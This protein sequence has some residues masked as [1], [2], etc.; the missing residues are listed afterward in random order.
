M[1]RHQ[2][3]RTRLRFDSV[4]GQPRQVCSERGEVPLE[5]VD[6]AGSAPA[7]VAEAVRMRYEEQNFD[8]EQE[9]PVRTAVIRSGD[10]LTHMVAIYLHLAID[11]TGF[12]VLLADLSARDPVTGAAPG[13]VTATQPL[14]QARQQRTPAAR[15]RCASSLRHLEHVLRTVTPSRF[16]APKYPEQPGFRMI[17]YRSPATALAIRVIAARDGVNT[18]SAL[19]ACFGIGLARFTGNSPVMAMLLVSNRFRPGFAESVSPLVQMSPYLIDVADCTLGEAVRRARASVLNTYKNAYYDPYLQDEVIERVNR[20][21][22]E[23]VDFSC[24]YNDRRLGDRAVPDGPLPTA[25][26]I[27]AAVPL[28]G[29]EWEYEPDM[30][31]RKLYLNVDDPEGAIDWVMSVDTRFFDETDTIAVV[32]GMETA[33][34]DAATDPTMPTGVHSAAFSYG[35]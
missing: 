20:E 15:R 11:A 5:I 7:A 4:D 8:Y 3:L 28:G 13:P 26:D 29:H 30:S 17:R 18:S 33:A 1:G 9:W 35:R 34:V 24:F 16:G 23:E 21:R 25:A 22:G 2:A 32:R 10:V 14:A 31:T 6:A 27:R 19:L 12:D